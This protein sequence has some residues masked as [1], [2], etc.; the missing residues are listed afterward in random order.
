[1]KSQ[2]GMTYIP[3]KPIRAPRKERINRHKPTIAVDWDGTLVDKDDSF[4]P[5]A[6]D[7]LRQLTKSAKVIIHSCRGTYYE[8]AVWIKGRLSEEGIDAE[9]WTAPGKPLADIYVDDRGLRF[10]NWEE[11]LVSLRNLDLIR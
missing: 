1:M 4:L 2:K 11:T 6:L 5:G 3:L 8:G 9:V 7:A 10:T